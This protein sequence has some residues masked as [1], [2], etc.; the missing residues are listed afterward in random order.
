[1]ESWMRENLGPE[2]RIKAFAEEG[3]S[4]LMRLPGVVRGLESALEEFETGGLKLHPDTVQAF[5]RRTHPASS[6]SGAL[7]LGLSALALIIALLALAF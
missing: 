3:Q 2:A 1:I 6:G 5:R 7:A 4:M